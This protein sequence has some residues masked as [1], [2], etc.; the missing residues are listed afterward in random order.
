[1]LHGLGVGVR[2]LGVLGSEM[3]SIWMNGH[4]EES[5]INT[6]ENNDT[7]RDSSARGYAYAPQFGI[8][9][10]KAEVDG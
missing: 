4:R 3:F 2:R 10:L 8:V 9:S 6:F 5:R 7:A 1:M